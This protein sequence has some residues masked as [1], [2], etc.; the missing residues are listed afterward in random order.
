MARQVT[1]PKSARA[2][3]PPPLREHKKFM[4]SYTTDGEGN[5]VLKGLNALKTEMQKPAP[6]RDRVSKQAGEAQ[7]ALRALLGD[8]EKVH[9]E[10][11]ALKDLFGSLGPLGIVTMHRE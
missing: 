8:A 4:R 5:K 2:K 11:P 9:Y 7:T 10:A 3:N 1:K 6:N